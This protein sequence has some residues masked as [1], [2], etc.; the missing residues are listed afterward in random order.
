[1]AYDKPLPKKVSK[2]EQPFWDALKKH[3]VRLQKCSSC[4]HTWFPATALC[5][6]CLSPKYEWAK[7][8]G[9]GKVFS[10][11][12]FHQRYFKS[13]EKDIP[14]SVVWVELEEGPMFYSNMVGVKNEEIRCDMP[15]EAYFDDVTDEFTLLKFKPA[16][17]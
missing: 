5:P 17:S 8:S 2:L 12:I 10:W 15:V 7:C 14:Y 13:F 9:K 16:K 1:M 11:V 6:R 4:G 3:E